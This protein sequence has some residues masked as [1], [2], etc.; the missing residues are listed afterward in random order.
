MMN[1]FHIHLVSCTAPR[2]T[3]AELQGIKYWIEQTF[4]SAQISRETQG[5]QIRFELPAEGH[6]LV[7]LIR[8]LENVKGDLGVEFYSIGKATLD[9][10]FEK[11]VKR[12]GDYTEK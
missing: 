11:I 10:V 5:G 4:P 2:T 12:Y 1:R 6:S 7:K 9:E 3:Q 8:I